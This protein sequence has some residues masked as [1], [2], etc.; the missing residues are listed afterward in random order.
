MHVGSFLA[1]VV[2]GIMLTEGWSV[3]AFC[4][5]NAVLALVVIVII[6][7]MQKVHAGK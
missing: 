5:T 3:N 7:I 1:P 2:G 4:A 6:F